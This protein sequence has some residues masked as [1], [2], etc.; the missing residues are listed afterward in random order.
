MASDLHPFEAIADLGRAITDGETNERLTR[1]AVAHAEAT[2]GSASAARGPANGKLKRALELDKLSPIAVPELAD[3]SAV[4]LDKAAAAREELTA[5]LKIEVRALDRAH[6]ALQTRLTG[7]KG[8]ITAVNAQTKNAEGHLPETHRGE[9]PDLS[10]TLEELETAL[11]CLVSRLNVAVAAIDKLAGAAD[12]AFEAVRLLIEDETFRRLE[13]HVADNLRRFTA[14]SAGR[15]RTA[16]AARIDV[17]R[18]HYRGESACPRRHLAADSSVIL[19][20]GI[21]VTI[22][23]SKKAVNCQNVR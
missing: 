18:A 13:P 2:L 4:D 19:T 16:L 3:A 17:R 21:S 11:D 8:K 22:S 10:L 9:F 5:G 23:T 6:A 14:R 12:D 15:E 7:I 20:R 1:D